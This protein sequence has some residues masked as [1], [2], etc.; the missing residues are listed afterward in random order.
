MLE[1][2]AARFH[3]DLKGVPFVGDSLK[4]AQAADAVGA[5]PILVLTGKGERTRG[6]GGLPRRTLVFEDLAEAARHIIA[7]A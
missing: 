6:E 7:H 1:E 2:I 5:Q 3:V 4:D